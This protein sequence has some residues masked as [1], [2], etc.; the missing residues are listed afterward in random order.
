MGT[1][2]AIIDAGDIEKLCDHLINVASSTD[3]ID[4]DND[5]VDRVTDYI[6]G[7]LRTELLR[8]ISHFG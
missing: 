4:L 7:Q 3:E 2:S 5:L 6:N 8:K 1:Q